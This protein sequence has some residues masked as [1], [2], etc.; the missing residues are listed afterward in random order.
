MLQLLQKVD[1]ETIE[2]VESLRGEKRWRTLCRL[3]ALESRVS[4]EDFEEEK[5]VKK[6]LLLHFNI[7]DVSRSSLS[8]MW[9]D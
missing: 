5:E 2:E 4:M 3:S 9:A 6:W 8:F 7:S 1:Q